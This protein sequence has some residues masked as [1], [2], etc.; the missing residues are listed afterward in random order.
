MSI[1]PKRSQV[2]LPVS[3]VVLNP[4]EMAHLKDKADELKTSY[5]PGR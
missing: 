1:R 3:M 4:T 2:A 5:S